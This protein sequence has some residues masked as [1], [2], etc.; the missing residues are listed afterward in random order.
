MAAEPSKGPTE[1]LS[2][3]LRE[4]GGSQEGKPWQ[5]QP[6]GSWMRPKQWVGAELWGGG[7]GGAHAAA[8]GRCSGPAAR[9][10]GGPSTRVSLGVSEGGQEV[11][12]RPPP[13]EGRS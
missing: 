13:G 5:R 2:S 7:P 10:G 8:R 6:R 12:G 11:L 9:A 3:V 4:E 1:G